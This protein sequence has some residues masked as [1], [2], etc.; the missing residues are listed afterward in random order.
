MYVSNIFEITLP[1]NEPDDKLIEPVTPKE[2]VICAEPEKGKPTP[3]PPLPPFNVIDA[4]FEVIVNPAT[5]LP[6]NWKYAAVPT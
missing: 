3:V 4:V 6:L 5:A 1:L 2:P